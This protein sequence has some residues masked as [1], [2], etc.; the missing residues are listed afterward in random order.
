MI[1]LLFEFRFAETNYR[2]ISPKLFRYFIDSPTLFNNSALL[3]NILQLHLV[4]FSSS[5]GYFS[6]HSSMIES[7]NKTHFDC[8]L[9]DC[10]LYLLTV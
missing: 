5:Y 4:L 10:L 7:L 6:M 8:T 2:F 9:P 3:N 1:F